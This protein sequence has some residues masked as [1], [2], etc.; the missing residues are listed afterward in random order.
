[1]FDNGQARFLNY[2]CGYMHTGL[3]SLYGGLNLIK[4]Q[5]LLRPQDDRQR[6]TKVNT[7]SLE[8]NLANT[9]RD[10]VCSSSRGY[11][12]GPTDVTLPSNCPGRRVLTYSQTRDLGEVLN[13]LIGVEVRS[14]LLLCFLF[15]YAA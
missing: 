6:E 1:M 7:T 3:G 4:L 12:A 14:R 5:I 2:N 11:R 8:A 15:E 13:G 9:Q 10:T